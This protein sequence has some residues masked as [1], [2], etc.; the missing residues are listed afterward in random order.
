MKNKN[1][2]LFLQAVGFLKE[3]DLIKSNYKIISDGFLIDVN[4]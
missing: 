4:I 2:K 3:H 1:Q